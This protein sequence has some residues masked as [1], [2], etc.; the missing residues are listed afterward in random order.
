MDAGCPGLPALRARPAQEE[1][2]TQGRAAGN[3]HLTD[4]PWRRAAE[5]TVRKELGLGAGK[6]N[7]HALPPQSSRRG[8]EP[9][10]PCSPART[11]PGETRTA[12]P[13]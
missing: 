8:S 2:P 4:P 6:L 5:N 3:Q 7:K 12:R 11:P 13:V 9:N 10:V 1:P